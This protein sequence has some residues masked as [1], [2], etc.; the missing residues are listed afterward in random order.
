MEV[1]LVELVAGGFI[2]DFLNFL[3]AAEM[4]GNVKMEAAVGEPGLVLHL[5]AAIS[6]LRRQLGKGLPCIERSCGGCRLDENGITA[7]LKDV[8][9]GAEPSGQFRVQ[10]FLRFR[11]RGAVTEADLE[12]CRFRHNLYRSHGASL[13][14]GGCNKQQDQ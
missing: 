9:F 7:D 12:G 6:L 4:T 5:H 2:Y 11:I 14:Y 13:N 3:L 8:T 1:E 10:Q